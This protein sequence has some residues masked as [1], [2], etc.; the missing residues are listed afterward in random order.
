MLSAGL[1]PADYD[2]RIKDSWIWKELYAVRNFRPS[3]HTAFGVFGGIF[4][5]AL[6]FVFRGRE[7]FTLSHGSKSAMRDSI[8]SPIL[9]SHRA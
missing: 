2:A 8:R 5:S 4:Y 9:I 1:E 3:F 6:H 7:P